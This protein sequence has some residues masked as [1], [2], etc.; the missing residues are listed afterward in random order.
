MR[1][2]AWRYDRY[3]YNIGRTI[4]QGLIPPCFVRALAQRHEAARHDCAARQRGAHARH[5][6]RRQP[7]VGV[8]EQQR[9][10]A[11]R[12]VARFC[13]RGRARRGALR[14]ARQCRGGARV[15]LHGL[16][17]GRDASARKKH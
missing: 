2:L 8:Q 16:A 17:A 14:A 13:A 11:R 12:V 10:V 5:R 7:R 9:S 3:A 15:H 6:I 4:V 1:Q